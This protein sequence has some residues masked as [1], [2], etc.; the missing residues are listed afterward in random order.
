MKRIAGLFFLLLSFLFAT[1]KAMIIYDASGSMWGQIDGVNKVVIARDALRSVVEKWNP[2]VE[3][4][5]T[6]YGHRVKGDC[7]DIQTLIPIGRVDKKRM[8][9]TVNA[10]MPKGMT[11]IARSLRQVAN[12]LRQYEDQTT[13]ILISDGK[14]SCDQDPCATARQLKAEGINFVAHVVGFNVNAA[15]D[16]QLSCIAKATG[17]E[18]FSAKNAASLTKAIKTIA[19]KVEKPKPKP[20]VVKNTTLELMA[21]YGMSAKGLNVSGIHWE[22]TQGGKV[23]Y[24]GD[25]ETPRIP[26]KVG[27]V[28]IK[29]TYDRTSEVQKIEGDVSLKPQKNNPIVIKLKSGRVTIDAAEEQGGPKVKA[30]VHI[31]PILD[32][33]PNMSDQ[34]AWCIPTPSKACERVLPIG[35]FLLKATYNEMKTERKFMLKKNETK[36]IHLSFAKTG[37]VETSASETEDGKW[38]NANHAIYEDDDGK[39]GTHMC[40]PYSRKKTPGKCRLPV[41][42]YIVKSSYNEF[43]KQTPITIKAGETTRLHVVFGSTGQIETS[44]SETEDGKWVSAYHTIYANEDG[45]PGDN[46]CS[47]HSDKKRAG[48]CKLPVGKYIV[49]SSYNE[50]KKQTPITIKQGETTKLHVLFGS[51]GMIETSASETDGGKWVAAYHNIYTDEAGKPG[52]HICS[53]H[54][55]KKRAGHRKLPVGKY[56]VKSSHN[57]FIKLTP[58]DVKAGETAKVHVVFRPFTFRAQCPKPSDRV[59][60]EIYASNGQMVT[61]K[62]IQCSKLW[63]TTLDNGTYTVEANTG[64]AS[65]KARFAVAP[66]KPDTLTLA[67]TQQ[68][69]PLKQQTKTPTPEKIQKPSTPQTQFQNLDQAANAIVKEATK[70]ANEHKDDLKKVGDLLNALGGLIGNQPSF[71]ADKKKVQLTPNSQDKAADDAF[72][73]VNDDLKMFTD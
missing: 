19:K 4:G 53:A 28:H 29:A 9:D 42:K 22:A 62:Q 60:W 12:S 7:N 71:P 56:I 51:T 73:K 10:I 21:R 15:T 54:S 17:G 23:L 72:D 25:K 41:G 33:Q 6:A 57:N 5:L 26:A 32:G 65:A 52:E 49:K 34:I 69:Q 39:P 68:S 31:Y 61:D 36:T 1:P 59:T 27:K 70:A 38:V 30:S 3:L 43:K 13:I 66:G 20:A 8:I 14:E 45:K 63:R 67:L 47:A 37:T 48:H 58:V 18:Y 50:F 24:R 40:S 2:K 55:D 46:I 35:D 64:R 16:R 44:A 11:P